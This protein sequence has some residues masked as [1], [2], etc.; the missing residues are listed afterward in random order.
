MNDDD[1]ITW[2]KG[3]LNDEHIKDLRITFTKASGED[4]TIRCTTAE[5][6]IPEDQ[7][8]RGTGRTTST[9]TTQPVFD[10]DIQQWRSFR[11]NSVK[12]VDFSLE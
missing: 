7:R 6:R 1:Q 4:R 9:K 12:Q 3:L 5:S 2:I 10:L 8:P 11:W